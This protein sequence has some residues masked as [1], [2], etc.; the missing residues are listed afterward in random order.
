[1]RTTESTPSKVDAKLWL[2]DRIDSIAYLGEWTRQVASLLIRHT[3]WSTKRQALD[4]R[5]LGQFQGPEQWL[6]ELELCQKYF[7]NEAPTDGPLTIH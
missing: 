1:M 5:P 3:S 4:P 2:H 7:V 6:R